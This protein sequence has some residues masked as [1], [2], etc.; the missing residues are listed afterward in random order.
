[1]PKITTIKVGAGG[2]WQVTDE[3]PDPSV[4]RQLTTHSCVAAVGEMLLRSRGISVSQ[5]EII[6][7]IG[8]P[9][10]V[11]FLADYLN[12]VDS[13]QSGEQWH[14][15]VIRRRNISTLLRSGTFAAVLRE[16]ST[17]GHLVLVRGIE[18]GALVIDDPWDGTSYLM[19]VLEFFR[20]WNGE[21]LFRWK[22]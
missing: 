22:L 11:E 18:N 8:E 2:F 10:G 20:H 15:L 13:D 4:V 16:G 3:H 14:G 5:Q 21:A 6:D 7:I 12:D 1:M 9:S 17:M 19:S